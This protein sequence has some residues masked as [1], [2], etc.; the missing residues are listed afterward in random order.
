MEGTDRRRKRGGEAAQCG[1]K[2]TCR[3]RNE[4][5]TVRWDHESG[6]T[7]IV[8][9]DGGQ[10]CRREHE[11]Q[12]PYTAFKGPLFPW[13]GATG[14][15]EQG[16]GGRFCRVGPVVVQSKRGMFVGVGM[17]PALHEGDATFGQLS[18]PLRFEG[19]RFPSG[20]APEMAAE[21][22][23]SALLSADV[24]SEHGQGSQL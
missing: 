5:T 1:E 2:G 23:V 7:R 17:F 9:G 21:P 10:T 4:A 16:A 22:A 20:V 3:E 12:R 11:A 8:K 15:S 14:R 19:R 18:G 6:T 13:E 24:F